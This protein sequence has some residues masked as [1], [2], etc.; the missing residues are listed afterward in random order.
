MG[1]RVT[2]TVAATGTAP[3]SYQWQREGSNL[4]GARGAT[5]TIPVVNASH[6]GDYSVVVSNAEGS[7][8]SRVARLTIEVP[9][10]LITLNQTW[11]FDASGA[12]WEPDWRESGFEDSAWPEGLAPFYN[13][14]SSL[15]VPKTTLLPVTNAV[16]E[17]IQTFYFRTRFAFSGEPSAR[18]LIASNYVD[19]GAVFYLNGR[20]VGRLRLPAGPITAA[21]PAAP[22]QEGRVRVM[23]FDTEALQ[24]GENVLA[25]E[26]HQQADT[27]P[28]TADM[29]FGLSLWASPIPPQMPDLI[30]WGPALRPRLDQWTFPASSC[31]IRDGLIQPGARRLLR[32]ATETR[33]IGTGDLVM[34]TPAD[35]PEFVFHA[36]HNHYH[37]DAYVEC[38]L[39]A[40]DQGHRHLVA[41]A[42][43]ASFALEDTERWD[44][45]AAPNP[46]Y[47]SS[48]SQGIQR[49]WSDVYGHYLPGQWIDVTDVPPGRYTLELELDPDRKIPELDESNNLASVEVEIPEDW[50]PCS[51]P[52]PNDQYARAEVI[53]YAVATAVG[54]TECATREPGEPGNPPDLGLPPVGPSV[55]YRWTAP[56]TGSVTIDTEGSSFDTALALF[57]GTNI[58]RLTRLAFDDEEGRGNTSLLT[59]NVEAGTE[60]FIQV[61]GFQ[62]PIMAGHSDQGSVILNFNA[63]AN[64]RPE[65]AQPLADRSGSITG[66][67]KGATPEARWREL[68][69]TAWYRWTAPADGPVEFHTLRPEG[70][71][72]YPFAA[73]FVEVLSADL[74]SLT[75][76]GLAD[77][78][79]RAVFRAQ[80]DRTY[81][82]AVEAGGLLP[83]PF[84][85]H[86]A[87]AL[88]LEVRG[89]APLELTLHSL[90]GDRCVI[91]TSSD[92]RTWQSWREVD[93]ASGVTLVQ[94]EEALGS[95]AR[96]FRLRLAEL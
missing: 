63:A 53:P 45:E 50:Q 68:P 64:D 88:R 77:P 30:V 39:V 2:F 59:A 12:E 48:S 81:F 52:P 96:F 86:W 23:L 24:V 87:D 85:L 27:R 10:P 92:L 11:R 40:Y 75:G 73:A 14:P 5:Y 34:G 47:S 8:T 21:T 18:Y 74:E 9:T 80:K 28:N 26:V 54:S 62:F 36:C 72:R 6:A 90:P 20:E 78:V 51:A 91:E 4:P 69:S 95:G 33:N 76:P 37:Y 31:E 56:Y 44:P 19:D 93:N 71:D 38:R 49:G 84:T 65:T 46:R 79:R 35:N 57:R 22:A 17:V 42:G 3:L 70:A 16:G 13:D 41:S 67:T 15:P 43:K 82:I 83:G 66:T 60:Y 94:V 32:F 25:V 7:V 61:Y 58:A 55:W 89:I 1:H 29:Y